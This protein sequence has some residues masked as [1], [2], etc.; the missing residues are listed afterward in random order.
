M[1]TV[2]QY[3]DMIRPEWHAAAACHGLTDLFYST[4][5]NRIRQAQ[6]ICA[7]CPVLERCAQ[8]ARREQPDYGTWAGTHHGVIDH[9]PHRRTLK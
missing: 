1:T 4:A 3:V 5:I 6:Q 8:Q 7:T 2:H 9:R